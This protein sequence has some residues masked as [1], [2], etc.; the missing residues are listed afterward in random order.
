MLA[1]TLNV[2]LLPPPSDTS[3]KSVDSVMSERI[4]RKELEVNDYLENHEGPRIRVPSHAGL[5]VLSLVWI[6]RLALVWV[7]RLDLV[8]TF[9]PS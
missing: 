6:L 3:A 5:P 2:I 1:V 7:L 8:G 4:L 9:N